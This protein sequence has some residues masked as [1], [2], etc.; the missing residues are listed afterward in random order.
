MLNAENFVAFG[1]V[2]WILLDPIQSAYD[3]EGV[4]DN[5][6][7]YTLIA[8][9]LS[10]AAMWAGVL[11]RP[12]RLPRFFM[13]V[14]AKPLET[15]AL[16]RI[17]PVCFALGMAK[18]IYSVGFNIP[19]M[20]S[21][22]GAPRWSAPWGRGQLGGWNAF[23]DQTEYFGYAL[24]SLATLMVVRKRWF[25][26]ES[27]LSIAAAL[28]MIAFL[29]QGGGRRIIGVTV[30]AAI[31]VWTLAQPGFR[32]S[33]L[34][35]VLAAVA[36]LLLGM[37]FI[38]EIRTQGFEDFVVHGAQLHYLHVDD[39]F[40]RLAQIIEIIPESHPFVYFQQIFF[41]LVR[42][43]P[44]VFWEGKPISGGFDLPSTIGLQGV[45]LSSSIV[46]EW[47][48]TFGWPAV[49]F[50]GWLHGRL[51]RTANGLRDGR[52]VARNPI[53]YG[54]AV[55][56]LVSGLRS[57]QDLVIMSYAILAWFGVT[58]IVTFR[59]RRGTGRG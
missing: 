48:M 9:G 31:I 3:L 40:L 37:Q 13:S 55:M 45:S 8:V 30:G 51:A 53:V 42:P 24:P 49:L 39:N 52:I 5:A 10:A 54:L 12:W 18:Y 46:G 1:Y 17:I 6:I 41:I 44:R 50:G 32:V 21:Y 57:M 27:L 34:V 16:R 4:S 43:I 22:L 56:V 23:L 26:P 20:F 14:V 25:N 33:M 36:A 35:G 29:A 2:Y 7:R 38:L 58:W 15:S 19:E 28:I 47:Y 11:A 59:H